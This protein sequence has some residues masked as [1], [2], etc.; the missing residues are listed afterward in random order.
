MCYSHEPHLKKLQEKGA[1]VTELNVQFIVSTEK[2][3][4]FCEHKQLQ[5]ALIVLMASHI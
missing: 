4:C 1:C 3:V 2:N 5:Y